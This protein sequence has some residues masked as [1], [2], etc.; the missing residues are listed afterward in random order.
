MVAR[1]RRRLG[2]MNIRLPPLLVNI[3]VIALAIPLAHWLL[4]P[5]IGY[6]NA[7]TKV[8]D[9]RAVISIPT[10]D[11]VTQASAQTGI[12]Q[13][14]RTADGYRTTFGTH[15][16]RRTSRT[17]AHQMQASQGDLPTN[18]AGQIVTRSRVYADVNGNMPDAYSN[19]DNLQVEWGSQE[20]YEIIRKIGRGKYSEVFEGVNVAN[21][22]SC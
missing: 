5:Y 13:T 6:F 20:N 14:A 11:A 8:D 1:H 17:P 10:G 9:I 19:Y 22:K 2:V 3:Y 12:E 21:S 7:R 15:R 18:E 16:P 4:Q